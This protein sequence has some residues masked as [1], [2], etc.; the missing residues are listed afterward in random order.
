MK[1]FFFMLLLSW[2]VV[3][4]IGERERK[5][6]KKDNHIEVGIILKGHDSLIEL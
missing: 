3:F 1:L 4:V 6:P 5:K 2:K